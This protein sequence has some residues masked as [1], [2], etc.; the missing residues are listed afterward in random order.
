MK[1]TVVAQSS[2]LIIICN[3]E[4]STMIIHCFDTMYTSYI[5]PVSVYNIIAT[6][7]RAMA[8]CAHTVVPACI[9]ISLRTMAYRVAFISCK[10]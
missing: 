8:P 5:I 4:N 9:F 3:I 2:P 1:S 7:M 6:L 10:T